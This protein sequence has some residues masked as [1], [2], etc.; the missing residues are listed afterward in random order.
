MSEGRWDNFTVYLVNE[1]SLISCPVAV[2]IITGGQ[3]SG[4]GTKTLVN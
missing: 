1:I 3:P 2:F 4:S